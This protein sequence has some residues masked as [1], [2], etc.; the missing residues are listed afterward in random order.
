[1]MM[2]WAGHVPAAVPRVLKDA[3]TQI[4]KRT[5]KVLYLLSSLVQ[6][7]PWEGPGPCTLVDFFSEFRSSIPDKYKDWRGKYWNILTSYFYYYHCPRPPPNHQVKTEGKLSANRHDWW[8]SDFSVFAVTWTTHS[9]ISRSCQ[10][11]AKAMLTRG[12]LWILTNWIPAR[13]RT[14]IEFIDLLELIAKLNWQ[15]EQAYLN[16]TWTLAP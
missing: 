9:P 16:P 6:R 14:F 12:C 3:F 13:E 1:M 7:A 4:P 5:T 15:H 2:L 11:H 10:G 8:W